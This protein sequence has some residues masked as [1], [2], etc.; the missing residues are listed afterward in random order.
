MSSHTYG[1]WER[2]EWEEAGLEEAY[3]RGEMQFVN[4]EPDGFEYERG[5]W[6]ITDDA[7]RTI[8]Y[9]TFGN[10]NFPGARDYTEAIVYYDD[11]E[12]Q[13]AVAEWAAKP[14]YLEESTK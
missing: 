3:R 2:S 14:E 4:C 11:G 13:A 6:Y 9:G 5:E 1:A 12:Y 8:F 7:A 10:Y